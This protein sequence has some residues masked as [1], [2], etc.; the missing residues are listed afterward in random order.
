M[1]VA[2]PDGGAGPKRRSQATPFCTFTAGGSTLAQPTRFVTSPDISRLRPVWAVYVPDY[3][4]APEHPFPAAVEDVRACYFDLADRGFSKIAITGD[5]AGGNLA[6]GLLVHLAKTG[7]TRLVGGVALSPVTDLSFSGNSWLSRAEADP[8]FTQP[9]AA[10]LA[11][12][13][14]SGK[15]CGRTRSHRLCSLN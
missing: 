6:L 7:G 1:L 14:L 11:A 4:L 3:R 10:A 5:S 2:S 9:Q 12:A 15:R 13:Y 8:L